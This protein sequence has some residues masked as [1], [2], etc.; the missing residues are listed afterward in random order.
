M[1]YKI[2][3]L[4]Y[5]NIKYV[6]NDIPIN[7]NFQKSNL[8]LLEGPN[9]Y[10]K[11]TVFDVIELLLTGSI[12]HFNEA[13]GNKS[14]VTKSVLIN[15]ITKNMVIQ[16]IFIDE[17][18][19]EIKIERIF[20]HEKNFDD[21]IFVDGNEINQ[22]E[23]FRILNI[24][25][26]MLGI[27]IYISQ[28]DSLN[29]LEKKYKDRKKMIGDLID[30]S[31]ITDKLDN[32]VEFEK[33]VTEKI[34]NEQKIA[35]DIIKNKIA[36]RSKINLQVEDI[37][38]VA[39]EVKYERLFEHNEYEFDKKQFDKKYSYN[40]LIS[41]IKEISGFIEKYDQ[42]EKTKKIM[43][44][45]KI[46]QMNKKYLKAI[47][48]EDDINR[49]NNNKDIFFNI[50]KLEKLINNKKEED[51]KEINKRINIEDKDKNDIEEILN[52]KQELV[53]QTKDNEKC[54]LNLSNK[55]KQLIDAYNQTVEK[56]IWQ[57]NKCPLCGRISDDIQEL[58]KSTE[59]ELEKN[60]VAIIIQIK[61]LNQ[62]IQEYFEKMK[63]I[64]EI[65]KRKYKIDFK[66][67][68]I[69]K[70]LLG[71]NLDFVREEHEYLKKINF[72]NE[73]KID[74]EIFDNKSIELN[75]KLE[76][77]I[78]GLGNKLEDAIISRYD[79][80]KKK[81]YNDIKLHSIDQINNKISYIANY[82]NSEYNSMANKIAEEIQLLQD[83]FKEID[84]K[85]K[86]IKECTKKY[87]EKY[88]KSFK[89]YQTKLVEKIKLPL[90]IYSGRIIQNYPMGLGINADIKSNQIVFETEI[91]SDDI[92]NYMSAG[93]LNGVIL[94]IML[95]VREILD[96]KKS[97]DLIMIDDPLQTI[98]DISA[99]S[100]ADLLAEQFGT[101]QII[102]STHEEEKADLLE[103]KFRQCNRMV[104]KYNMHDK[105]I[106]S[107]SE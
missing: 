58:L 5:S 101:A 71:V 94:S 66:D 91:K 90:Y 4:T 99:F 69:L 24:N 51:I 41:P 44:L 76:N 106:E 70:D 2:K 60:I 40:T 10:G 59:I 38:K 89:E 12:S 27:A 57:K 85:N 37:R 67:Y 83:D 28:L 13:I 78:S 75:E 52:R 39:K 73:G 56:V 19:E 36:E 95:A 22:E 16:A 86:V 31:N 30:N 72:K 100:Y 8:V 20:Y 7:L 104:K 23:L 81:Y 45:E 29:F 50:E 32:L 26:N 1:A 14:E 63:K 9:G 25:L 102:L 33:K 84:E 62:Y 54:I 18:D 6:T 105:Y 64:V 98:D 43:I 61:Q 21:E 34:E 65:M 77:E 103:F 68:I 74:F 88:K 87:V 3:E 35:G 79:S 53:N 46:L 17:N 93:Q 107:R 82:F 96:F 49:V 97:I 80:L 92:F 48:Y 11:S 15:N 42:Y 55:R 47:F